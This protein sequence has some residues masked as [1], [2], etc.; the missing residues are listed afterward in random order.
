MTHEIPKWNH[1]TQLISTSA[2]CV[3]LACWFEFLKSTLRPLSYCLS[4]AEHLLNAVQGCI[5]SDSFH[6]FQ[7]WDPPEMRGIVVEYKTIQ[8]A[9]MELAKPIWMD[10]Q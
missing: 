4:V 8:R 3:K 9:N 5:D 10:T 6:Q 7:F 2:L 1:Q